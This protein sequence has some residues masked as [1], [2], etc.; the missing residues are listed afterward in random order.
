MATVSV[1]IRTLNESRY[2]PKLLESLERD[3]M[4]SEIETIVVDSG[5]T[6]G[7]PQIARKHGAR[8]LFLE[9]NEF[10]FGRSLNIG[11]AAA[12][13][14]IFAFVSGHCIPTTD[15]WL[16]L[17]VS[18]LVSRI[19]SY[20]YGR[21][22]GAPETLFSEH[23]IFR[24]YFPPTVDEAPGGCFCNN[25]NAALLASDWSRHRFRE[26]LTGLEDME[27]AKRIVAEGGSIKYVPEAV[28]YHCHHETWRAIKLRYEREALGLRY[29]LPEIHVN[30]MVATRFFIAAI[31]GDLGQAF[32][33]RCLLKNFA[34]I[35]AFRFC[36][37]YGTWIGCRSHAQ[38]SR[39]L[40]ERYFYPMVTKESTKNEDTV[41][42]PTD[43][44]RD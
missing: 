20:A 27:L 31:A 13:G 24:K 10:S 44:A 6:D 4:F 21:Q 26:D 23:Q 19:A 2:L 38:I 15:Q 43:V 12:K 25:A 28:V 32:R 17:L 41:L 9:R 3:K 7:T 1:I 14:E 11:C 30:A 36:Q 29:I 42:Q 8:V 22:V 35:A 5:S 40:R 34:H 16:S 33:Q 18:P 39:A 37:Y